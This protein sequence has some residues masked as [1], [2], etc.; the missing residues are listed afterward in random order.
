ML[1]KTRGRKHLRLVY[2]QQIEAALVQMNQ[3]I[4]QMMK[5][6]LKKPTGSCKQKTV[7]KKADSLPEIISQEVMKINK[8]QNATNFLRRV[9]L[10]ES[11]ST[12]KLEV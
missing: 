6:W 5:N 8:V 3:Y 7:L 9:I 12:S 4:P 1:R 2:C 10:A 11:T